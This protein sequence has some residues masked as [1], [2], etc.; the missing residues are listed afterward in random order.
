MLYLIS[1]AISLLAASAR[2]SIVHGKQE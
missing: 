2:L 1:T